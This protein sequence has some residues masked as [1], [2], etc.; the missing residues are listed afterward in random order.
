MNKRLSHL[1]VFVLLAIPV[2][3]MAGQ[4][5]LPVESGTVTS[6]VGWRPDPFGS[7]KFFFHR[8]IDI[9]V[10]TGTPVYATQAGYVFFSGQYGAY[11]NLVAVAHGA[12]F[13][14][15]YG[16]NSKVLVQPGQWVETN[17][18]IALSGNTGRSTGP[19]VHY[20]VRQHTGKERAQQDRVI[21][22]MKR[23][24]EAGMSALASN[25]VPLPREDEG[26]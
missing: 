21:E 9:S 25:P 26:V 4:R 10:P 20:E 19:H 11:G 17:T 2:F 24:I 16:H 18:V 5:K 23:N 8:G 13:L 12:G 6:G 15:L 1:V 3:A 14:T 22:A 7:G